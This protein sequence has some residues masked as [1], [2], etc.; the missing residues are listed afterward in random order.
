M[1]NKRLIKILTFILVLLLG[2]FGFYKFMTY[3]RN[4]TLTK[5]YKE[6]LKTVAEEFGFKIE[7]TDEIDVVQINRPTDKT[8]K[9][10]IQKVL[11]K[12][13][14]MTY[15]HEFGEIS[16][17]TSDNKEGFFNYKG[18]CLS[19]HLIGL[20]IEYGNIDDTTLNS[21]KDKLEKQF[22]NYKIKWTQL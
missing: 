19:D 8:V 22:D 17:L 21:F 16:K 10:K 9:I 7:K 1:N 20:E 15:G 3:D 5:E 6:E 2:L 13:N 18:W 14:L 4:Y 12:V 11:S